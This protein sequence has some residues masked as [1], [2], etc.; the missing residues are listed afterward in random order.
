MS[1]GNCRLETPLSKLVGPKDGLGIIPLPPPPVL[2]FVPVPLP[3]VPPPPGFVPVPE[4][5]PTSAVIV[6]Y[7][8]V[9]MTEQIVS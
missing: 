2:E 7:K 1:W 9:K 3:P 5:P 8:I 4:L 6:S